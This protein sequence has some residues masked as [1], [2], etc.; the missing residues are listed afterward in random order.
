MQIRVNLP[1][2]LA[3]Q[4]KGYEALYEMPHQEFISF[5]LADFILRKG[6]LEMTPEEFIQ[7]MIKEGP[8]KDT[9]LEG[10]LEE[11]KG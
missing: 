11:I 6:P 10:A 7:R 1:K 8:V 3:K 4:V 5:A 2:T 9:R